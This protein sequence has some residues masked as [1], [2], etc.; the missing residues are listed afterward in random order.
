[1]RAALVRSLAV[2]AVGGIALAAV[3]FVAS[4]V[5]ARP[6][7]VVEVALTQPLAEDERLA[8][9]TTSIEI[10]FSELVDTSSAAEAVTLDPPVEGAVSWIGST[11]IFTPDDP[12]ELETTYTLSIGDGVRDLAGNAMSQLPAPFE[13]GTAGRPGLA[14]SNPA[15]GDEEVPLVEPIALTFTTLMDTASVEAELRLEPRFPHDLRW[16]GELL[17]I[18]PSQPL[19]PGQEY[20]VDIGADAADVA[21]VSLG[22]PITLRFRTVAPGL[23]AEALVPAD[24]VDGIAPTSPIAVIFD[25][26]VDP[27]SVS[28]DL[29]TITPDVAGSLEL[30]TTG[31]QPGDEE[32]AARIIQFVPSGPLPANTTFEVELAPGL[33]NTT[34]GGLGGPL[35]WTFT[36]GAP[37][38][39][40]SNQIAFISDRAGVAN[41]WAMNPDGTGQRQVSSELTPVLD[42]AVA[43]DGSSLV[44]GDGRRLVYLRADGGDRR[45]LTQDGLLEFDPTY[46]PDGGRI[47]FAR[48]DAA[49]GDGLGLWEWG[50]G[51]GDATPIDL[52][53]EV[54]EP[55]PSG[56]A[57]AGATVRT[58]RYA[59][60]G[61]ALAFVDLEGWVGILDLADD[62]LTRA[63]FDA[64]APPIWLPDSSGIVLTGSRSSRTPAPRA[65]AE[66]V[67]PLEPERLDA[68]YRLGRS[69]ATVGPAS[70]GPGTTALAVGAAGQIAYVDADG[71]LWASEL[72]KPTSDEPI[73]ADTIAGA[74]FAPGE[75]AIVVVADAA[76]GVGRLELLDLDSGARSP[77]APDGA[78]PRW[79]P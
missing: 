22:D 24:G 46:A 41:V 13:F 53:T 18:V 65:F 59:P 79:L 32:G 57:G 78:R 10:A 70:F 4:T 33:T 16:S 5:D 40:L 19:Q 66:P 28:D 47:A 21:G 39:V 12:L 74:S 54:G 69:S 60:D 42:Y 1:M 44:V 72:P 77:L 23:A 76:D 25:R 49:T 48:A 36:T 52:P 9:I 37:S 67:V 50:I 31:D 27:Q 68:V 3:L 14:G 62:E 58:P 56:A 2:I 73:L 55:R 61:T 30:V 35:T 63:Q 11:M 6:P 38:S 26:P 64:A 7:A 20:E 29:L 71:F 75:P 15:D 51:A 34:G 45:E 8:L 17:E 43:P